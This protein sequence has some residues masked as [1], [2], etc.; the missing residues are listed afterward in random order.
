M[1]NPFNNS[2]HQMKWVMG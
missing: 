1:V 2:T